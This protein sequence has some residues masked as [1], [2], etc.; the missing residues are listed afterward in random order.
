[1]AAEKGEVSAQETL[2]RWLYQGKFI[3]RD[4]A[5]ALRWLSTA[6]ERGNPF[7]QAWMGDVLSQGLGVVID[8]EAA[9]HWY[10]RAA[11]QR[12]IGAL[13]ILTAM[14]FGGVP[15]DDD[16]RRIFGLWLKLAEAGEKA[17]QRQVADLYI[18]AIGTERSVPEA[19][20]WLRA[21]SAQGDVDAQVRLGGLLLLSDEIEQSPAEAVQMFQQAAAQGS[22]D[23]EYNLGVCFRRGIGVPV[24]RE[25]ARQLYHHAA[26]KGNS[27]AQLALGD[28]LVE[29]G[30]DESLRSAAQWY[31]QASAAG[32]PQASYGLARLY[33]AGRGVYADREKAIQL[34]GK[35]A[36]AGYA[37]AG[38]AL[39]RLVEVAAD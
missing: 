39:K 28:L 38:L 36:E 12:H 37:E 8:R 19:V 35:A 2:G 29:I 7:A 16:R 13:T 25:R 6:A 32:V 24:D 17:A 31:E 33:E 30:D 4:E 22:V 27:S 34:N 21:A 10:E 11:E 9:R 1:M 26:T 15:S 20:K 3:P 5:R 18:S 23:A 14:I